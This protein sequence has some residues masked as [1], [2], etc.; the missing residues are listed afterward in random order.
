ML[1]IKV[2]DKSRK[3]ILTNAA[4]GIAKQVQF[5]INTAFMHGMGIIATAMTKSFSYE[6]YGNECPVNL[7]VVTSQPPSTGKSGVNN[8]FVSPVRIAFVDYNKSQQIKRNKI[9]SKIKRG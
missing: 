6:Y 7:Y 3:D 1:D 9:E 8:F 2:V 5:P 4:I